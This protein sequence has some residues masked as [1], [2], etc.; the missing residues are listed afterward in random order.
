MTISKRI[1]N[2]EVIIRND[3][4]NKVC[5]QF[6]YYILVFVNKIN[7]YNK[8]MNEEINTNIFISGRTM[9]KIQVSKVLSPSRE[10]EILK[11]RI[12][13]FFRIFTIE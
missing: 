12:P 10:R 8:H 5:I 9:H 4:I 2:I 1:R 6:L 11:L 3:L 13:N 7:W